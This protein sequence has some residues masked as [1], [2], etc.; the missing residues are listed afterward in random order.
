MSDPNSPAKN[1]PGLWASAAAVAAKT[2]E[3]RNRYVDFLR[4]LSI[5]AVVVGH[6]LM[7]APY[8]DGGGI[9]ISSM[10]E[11]QPWTRWLSWAFQVMPVFFLVG[12]YANG[13]SWRAARRDGRPYAEWLQLR[14]QRLVGPVLP[15]IAF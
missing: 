7:A 9:Q 11:H 3:S 15:L 6:W 5:C 13:L 2:P 14:L 12:G 4:A 1:R 8:I 10:L